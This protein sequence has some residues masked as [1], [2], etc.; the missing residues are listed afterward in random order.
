[1]PKNAQTPTGRVH[2][3]VGGELEIN[4]PKDRDTLRKSMKFSQIILKD[5]IDSQ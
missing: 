1:M 5:P 4:F 3:V 2:A